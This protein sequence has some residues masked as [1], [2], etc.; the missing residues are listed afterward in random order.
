MTY[1]RG[2]VK[3]DPISGEVAVRTVFPLGN[4]PE[5][6]KLEWLCAGWGTGPRNTNT[7]EVEEWADIFVA[8]PEAPLPS[9]VLPGQ[10]PDPAI[11]QPTVTP[12]PHLNPA[13]EES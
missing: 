13:Q 12:L 10:E 9:I 3:R 5:S 4:D 2:H 11:L 7:Q 6:Q 1:F 8:D